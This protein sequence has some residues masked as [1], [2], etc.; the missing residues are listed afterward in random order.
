MRSLLRVFPNQFFASLAILGLIV[1]LVTSKVVL[2]VATIMIMCNAIINLRIAENFKKWIGDT[3][4]VLLIALFLVYLL[5]G[6]Y[7]DDTGYWVDRC[8]MK[9]PFLA[10]PLGF[11]DS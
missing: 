4:S 11:H 1:G 5:T 9:L 7:S 10:L 2:S 6:F 8:R 3:T